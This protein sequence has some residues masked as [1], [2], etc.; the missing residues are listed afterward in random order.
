VQSEFFNSTVV[1]GWSFTGTGPQIF[2]ARLTFSLPSI[3][4]QPQDVRR[5]TG[6]SAGFCAAITNATNPRFQWIKDGIS[7]LSDER[8]SGATS[9]CLTISNIQPSDAGNYW[10]A[11][12]ADNGVVSSS[13]AALRLGPLTTF[14]SRTILTNGTFQL[15]FAGEPGRLYNIEASSSPGFEAAVYITNFFCGQGTIRVIDWQARQYPNR[16]YRAVSAH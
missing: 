16:F 3:I 11:V 5:N 10:L 6:E 14:L 4:A 15:D 1:G 2:Q 13:P 7:L 12:V 9:T 8:I